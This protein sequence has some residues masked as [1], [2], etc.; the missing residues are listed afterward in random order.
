[1]EA[2]AGQ[3]VTAGSVNAQLQA[4]VSFQ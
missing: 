2:I 3:T 4:V 1:L